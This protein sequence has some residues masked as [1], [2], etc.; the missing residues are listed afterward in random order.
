MSAGGLTQAGDALFMIIYYLTQ[1]GDYGV[2]P[3]SRYW[4]LEL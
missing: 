4:H 3:L 2:H 1:G